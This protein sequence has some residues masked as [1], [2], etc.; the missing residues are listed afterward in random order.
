M[1]EEKA[2]IN[3]VRVYPKRTVAARWVISRLD[4]FWFLEFLLRFP[5]L[6]LVVANRARRRATETAEVH[7]NFTIAMRP[8]GAGDDA[9]AAKLAA[10]GIDA[11]FRRT[12]STK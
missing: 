9:T 2:K 3:A 11:A 7:V 4:F 5:P 12:R 6:N 1:L 10:I 8:T